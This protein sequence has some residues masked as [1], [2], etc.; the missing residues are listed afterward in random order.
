MNN[1]AGWFLTLPQG[2]TMDL[3]RQ[4][5][6]NLSKI[7]NVSTYISRVGLYLT[8]TRSTDVISN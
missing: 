6:G 4:Q 1:Q 2:M 7:H 5:I 3:A 8:T